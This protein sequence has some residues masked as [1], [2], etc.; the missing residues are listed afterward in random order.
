MSASQENPV[1]SNPVLA[2]TNAA[3]EYRRHGQRVR[4]LDGVDLDRKSVV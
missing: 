2:L 3:V 1:T 4:A